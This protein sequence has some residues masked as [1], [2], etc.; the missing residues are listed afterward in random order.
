MG[1]L[2]FQLEAQ[3]ISNPNKYNAESVENH[4]YL[5]PTVPG[6]LLLLKPTR[7]MLEREHHVLRD[8]RNLQRL[9]ASTV[10]RRVKCL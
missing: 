5:G 8:A 1:R 6:T 10:K 3:K 4:K 2:L 7:Q 9:V